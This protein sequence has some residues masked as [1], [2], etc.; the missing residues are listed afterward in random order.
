MGCI[1]HDS[2]CAAQRSLFETKMTLLQTCT[3]SGLHIGKKIFSFSLQLAFHH[4]V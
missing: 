4:G 1:D 3:T 2:T